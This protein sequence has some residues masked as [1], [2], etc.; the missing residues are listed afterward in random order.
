MSKYNTYSY[1]RLSTRLTA[2][3]RRCLVV[4]GVLVLWL[5]EASLNARLYA[6]V[7]VFDVQQM[8]AE[9]EKLQALFIW[10][11][12]QFIEF[13]PP[14]TPQET[15]VVGVVGAT[16]VETFLGDVVKQ[17][18]LGDGRFVE[19]RKITNIDD[20]VRC[21]AVFIAPSEAAKLAQILAKTRGK[22]ILTIGRDDTLL[23]K[24]GLINFYVE[25][26][27][28]RFEYNV[29]E[30]PNSKLRFSSKLMRLGRQFT[31]K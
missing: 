31:K 15:F 11:F 12:L 25:N 9:E 22:P 8:T 14:Q 29:D 5:C 13:P 27:K 20:I 16:R 2:Y 10:Q 6:P 21:N 3:V 28:V 7:K 23:E 17:K 26:S 1:A 30:I 24:G 19:V 18:Q 4:V